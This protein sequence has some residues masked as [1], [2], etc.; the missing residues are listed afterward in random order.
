MSVYQT[1]VEGLRG[2]V[3]QGSTAEAYSLSELRERLPRYSGTS[4]KQY[5]EKM[6]RKLRRSY[7]YYQQRISMDVAKAP[8]PEPKQSTVSERAVRG[9]QRL[10][11]RLTRS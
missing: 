6:R 5:Q 1:L 11:K 4:R 2:T 3:A 8:S 9:L 7:E 10:R